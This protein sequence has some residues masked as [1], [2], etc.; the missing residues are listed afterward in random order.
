MLSTLTVL[1]NA[2]SGPGSLRAEIAAAQSGDTI[3]FAPS[4]N[5]QT[6]ALSSGE[7]SITNGVTI[8]GPG[9]GELTISGQHASRVFDMT[10]GQPVV[11]RG[12]TI[13]SG[14]GGFGGGIF[15]SGDLTLSQCSIVGGLAS[16]GG[17]VYNA[18]TLAASGC[19]L[20]GDLAFADGGGIYASSQSTTDL[21][22]CTLG[23]NVAE[24]G[25]N[26]APVFGGGLYFSSLSTRT[27]HASAAI[28]NCT[29]S[30]NQGGG[31]V[32]VGT[33]LDLTNTIVAGNRIVGGEYAT[34]ADIYGSVAVADHN[35]VGNGAG[36]NVVSGV[37]GNLVGGVG[38]RPIIN[39]LL[40]PLANNG[41][42]TE[43]MALLVGSPAIGTADNAA[44]PATDQ[45]GVTRQDVPGEATDIGAFEF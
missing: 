12:L 3:V 34:G 35:L 20:S 33:V 19:T 4:L 23:G 16:D 5:G 45:R 8:Q 11:L 25:G 31:I 7:L 41:G 10:S 36:S 15:N 21:T 29:I 32:L 38:G 27:S 13:S 28:T 22:N 18:G 26:T 44:A 39:A 17:G 40:G 9:A 30:Q 6:I 43:T 37:N 1:N 14:H 42:P 24:S 2:D